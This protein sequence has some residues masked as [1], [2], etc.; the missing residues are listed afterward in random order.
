MTASG[1][2]DVAPD[3]P[4]GAGGRGASA[5]PEAPDATDAPPEPRG[6]AALSAAPPYPEGDDVFRTLSDRHRGPLRRWL[7][8]R[9]VYMDLA[10]CACYFLIAG[11]PDLL[12]ATGYAE[13]PSTALPLMLPVGVIT[14]ALFF[15]R[16]VPL[17]VLAVVAV[18]EL[19][20]MVTGTPLNGTGMGLWFALYAVALHYSSSRTYALGLIVSAVEAVAMVAWGSKIGLTS[21]PEDTWF[22]VASTA[23]F[24]MVNVISI[25]LGSSVRGN[26]L[27]EAELEGW[28]RRVQELAKGRERNRIA[29]EMH[30]IVAH[31]LSV[32]IALSDGAA[33]TAGRNPERAAAVMAD[34][35]KAGRSALADLRRSLGVLRVAGAAEV[36]L[37]PAGDVAD[38]DE[39]I[40]GFRAAGLP[41]RVE[42]TGEAELSPALGMTAHRIVQESLTNALR[43]AKDPTRVDV[44]I[45]S[46]PSGVHLRV[47]DDGQQAA[48]GPRSQGSGIGLS[49]MVERAR[50][51]G[52]TVTAGP[53]LTGGWSVEAWLPSPADGH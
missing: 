16:R 20:V 6:P 50:L 42:R 13:A 23:L 29:G 25:V 5:S 22:M 38:F 1:T 44:S 26:R 46:G 36:P 28:A 14:I 7:R 9:P 51:F 43:Y 30:D 37:T 3:S 31:S 49:G 19:A 18:S 39:M 2:R 52:G 21:S 32:M 45:A 27:H 10:V 48:R 53:Q 35:S 47:R 34:V 8:R 15:R 4:E 17:V 24:I 12:D 41:L 11:V 40:D 33:R